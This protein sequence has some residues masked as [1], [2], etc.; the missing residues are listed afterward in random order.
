ML[1]ASAATALTADCVPARPHARTHAHL[2]SRRTARVAAF[3]ERLDACAAGDVAFTLHLDDPAGNSALEW[4][5]DLAGGGDPALQ[6]VFYDRTRAQNVAIGCLGEQQAA[7]EEEAE[8]AAKE[9][10]FGAGAPKLGCTIAHSD[11]A[12]IMSTLSRYSAPEE[13]MVFPGGCPMCRGT[14]DTRM[15][16]TRIPYFREVVV[17]CTS[18][19]ACGYRNADLRAGGPIPEQGRTLTLAVTTAR[20][21]S[22]DLIKSETADVAI[23]ELELELGCGTLG[24]RVTTVEGL[25]CEVRDALQRTRFSTLGDSA[26]PRVRSTW[27]AFFAALEECITGVTPFTLV[28]RDPLASCYISADTEDPSAD[29]K[30]K[31]EE[32]T[33]TFDEDEEFGLHDID[34][35]DVNDGSAAGAR[36]G[37][38]EAAAAAAAATATVAANGSSAA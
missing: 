26:V 31:V 21:L 5:G 25:L 15:F 14:A 18:C 28:L 19:D 24:G 37:E 20:D 23:P 33:R 30:L 11:G 1:R 38:R 12:A 4:F 34:T 16:A 8:R 27:D 29:P 35:G 6:R 2:F 3:C 17:M 36:A 7:D 10:S 13:V 32:F 22:R 9:R